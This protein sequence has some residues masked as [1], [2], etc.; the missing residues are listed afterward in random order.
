MKIAAAAGALLAG[1]LLAWR[2]LAGGP[3]T[4]GHP[5]ILLIT[6]D[7]TR[8]DHLGAYGDARAE[9]PYLD[10]LASEGILFERAVSAAPVTLPAHV[11]L[12]TG[13]YPFAHGVRNNGNFRVPDDAATLATLLHQQGYRTAAFV[14][15]FVLDRRTGLSRGF[16]VYNDTLDSGG[17]TAS[18][19]PS[20]AELER[21]GDRTAAAARA[22]L[23]A[24]FQTAPA[25][26]PPFF[27]WVHLYDPH[28]PY[29]PPPP[30]A[31][32]FRD[33]PYD[34][35]IAFDD[36][37]VGSILRDVDDGGASASTIVT[38]VGDHGESL[39][40]H[41][42]AT[43]GMFVYESAVR[44]P[45]IVRWPGH[46][47]PARVAALARSVDVAPTLVDLA[48]APA[49]PAAQG[50]SLIPMIHG[51]GQGP[52]F[53]YTETYFPLF[54]MDWAP[55]RSIQDDRWKFVDAP[56]PELYDLATDPHERVNV[57]GRE[58]ARA[59]A[60]RR[61]LDSLA[62][63]RDAD[64]HGNGPAPAEVR[65]DRETIDKL[66]ALGYVGLD[67]QRP[68]ES[69]SRPDPKAMIGTFN[70]LRAANAAADRGHPAEAEAEARDIL[71]RD[72]RN[73]FALSIVGKA[74]RQQGRCRD[75]ITAYKSYAALVPTGADAHQWIAVCEARLGH[76]DGAVAEASVAI[77]LD[78]RYAA[79]R[80]LRAGLLAERG[81]LDEATRDYQAALE[82]Q[83]LNPDAH[84]GFGVL[85]AA[86]G[87]RDRAVKELT[88]A[89]ELRPDFDEVRMALGGLL[90]QEGRL[91][92]ARAQY[93]AVSNRAQ[94]PAE[95]RRTAR[96]R[97]ARLA[98]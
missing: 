87:E 85:L 69:G 98:K 59:A 49:L 23:T 13:R 1:A 4:D 5:N 90:E 32:R 42:E 24:Y 71:Q 68:A 2:L 62:G 12:F 34:G 95:T 75:A 39:G 7:T 57:A 70:R 82:L 55:L 38:V 92:D 36:S 74:A 37:V 72:P 53:A 64:R 96:E 89:L 28:D 45:L 48:G 56:T 22:W 50:E 16:D 79:P 73:A 15:A 67:V 77:D 21:R 60:L 61:G 86:R 20:D 11:S 18:G 19:R 52:L 40:E 33:R 84:G 81:R 58:P 63:E 25:G 76:D 91:A 9:T 78:S 41:G 54:F 8:A 14:S 65:P 44:V 10:R 47:R 88:R 29:D 3:R 94:A 97:L 35:E 66:A 43:H 17:L 80:L 6:L 31:D 83:P 51:R 30:F 93:E 46:L 27:V 26:R